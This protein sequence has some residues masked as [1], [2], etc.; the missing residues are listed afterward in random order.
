MYTE[1]QIEDWKSKAEKYDNLKKDLDE[2]Y[3][4]N[5]DED[6]DVWDDESCAEDYEF[7]RIIYRHF[8]Y[9]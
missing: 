9:F 4:R 6:L 5:Y 2:L 8:K 7:T 1:V 3:G